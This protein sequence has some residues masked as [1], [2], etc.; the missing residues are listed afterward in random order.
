MHHLGTSEIETQRLLLR[1]L[2]LVDAEQMYK[3]WASDE[4]VARFVTWD[5]HASPA[6]TRELLSLWTKQY[7]RPDFYNWGMVIKETGQLIGTFSFVA[8][9]E[10]DSMAEV[11]YCIGKHWWNKG[12]VT[13]AGQ[14]LLAFGFNEIGLNRIQAVHDVRNPAS[15]RMM[16]KL[17]MT[18]E[19]VMRQV[20]LVKGVLVKL[21]MC[22]I[23][24]E[25]NQ[26]S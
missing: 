1:P 14:A 7:D 2:T 16:E 15:G 21:A 11:G 5:T 12:Y 8:V 6:D 24:A 3:N 18:H 10:R 17:G 26:R 19:G 25:D 23:L 4:D 20:R 22:A 13:E 9:S